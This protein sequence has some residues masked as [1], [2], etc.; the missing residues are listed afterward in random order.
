MKRRTGLL[1]LCFTAQLVCTSKIIA[2]QITRETAALKNQ[3][4]GTC[5]HFNQGWDYTKVLPI[6]QDLGVAWVRDDLNWRSVEKTK[7]VYTVPE[8]TMEWI[9]AVHAHG[10]KLILILNRENKLYTDPYDADAYANFCK[11]MAV[12]LKDY[13][14][15]FEIL[16]EPANFGFR[17]NYG[18]T[19]NGLEPDGSTGPWV[20][21][22]VILINKA[23]EAIKSVN[24]KIK[25]IGL[26]SVAPVN[27]KQL[28]MGIS[29]A[30]DGIVDH[31]YSYR[32]V[33]EI[34]SFPSTEA[35]LK[36]DGIATADTK[37]T[38]TSQIEMYRQQSEKY[39]GP[40]EIWLT[41]SGFV[42]FQPLDAKILNA[43]LTEDAQAKYV[44]RRFM[45][46]LGMDIDV[47]LQY[48]LKN[49]GDNIHE[50]EHN[51][52]IINANYKPKP[53]FYA[54]QRVVKSTIGWVHKKDMAVHIFSGPGRVD[55]Y[56]VMWDGSKM[57]S[58]NDI[59]V[60]T[61]LNAKGQEVVT[62]WS[63]ERANN[64]FA[65]RWADIEFMTAR[66]VS[67]ITVMD[68]MTGITTDASF[69]EIEGGVRL[70][71]VSVPDH[72]LM[73]TIN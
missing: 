64:E 54:Y 14:D 22:Y 51:Y 56:P 13:A 38:L 47:A 37:G 53:A 25:V 6:V 65:P 7:G 68:M 71:T 61:F 57:A 44:Q 19:W 9:K 21:K 28:A 55:S 45:Q 73:F 26:G 52:G 24:K 40:K 32:T 11:A 43:G 46:Y 3:H 29:P 39:K 69:K 31:P 27:F 2:Q 70:K 62:L 16:N 18:G 33:P 36:R 1:L 60:Y 20:G 8:K 34:I 30:V 35:G 67:K 63:S 50:L 5:V 23:A 66:K 49:D 59:P 41:E 42:T 4:F 12:Q 17:K 58:P 15:A 48:D 72:V 10:I